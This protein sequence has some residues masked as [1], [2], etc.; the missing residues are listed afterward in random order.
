M[1]LNWQ[2]GW[3]PFQWYNPTGDI[4]APGTILHW[5]DGR[6]TDGAQNPVAAPI[7]P[8][9]PPA[10]AP[11]A[12]A[13]GDPNTP[14][15]PAPT[16]PSIESQRNDSSAKALIESALGQ[17]GLS[18]LAS[19]AWAKWQA[20]ESIDQIMLELRDTPEYNA[21][22]P[23]MKTLA[24][25]GHAIS[26]AQYI[27]YEQQVSAIFHAA[28]LP[29]GF[30]DDPS[31]YA[32]FLTKNIS[33]TELQQRVQAYQQAAFSSPQEVR[34]ALRDYYGVS[35]GE[36]T[37]FW[38]NPD[39]AL[40]LIQKRFAAAQA[41]GWS[42]RSG[43]GALSKAQAEMVGD[44]GLS[45]EELAQRFGKLGGER[46]LF[47]PLVG[48]QGETAIGTD[49]AL[50]AEFDQNA[51]AQATIDARKRGRIAPFVGGGA[52]ATSQRGAIGAGRAS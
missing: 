50:A 29:S 15:A 24:G 31:D 30:Y 26:E 40:P 9:A 22:F 20:G 48:N 33:V 39:L 19:W 34:D 6:Y 46:G 35:A 37:A 18:S 2:P 44:H 10:P 13:A 12:P 1:A 51:A 8:D 49:T 32:N 5:D 7:D 52:V 42:K 38:I 14:S 16:Q 45:E 25:Q 21:R 36:L 41:E 3:G 11:S 23:A 47:T 27:N 4:N 43:F 17:Y 28:G